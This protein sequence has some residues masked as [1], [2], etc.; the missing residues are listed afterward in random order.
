MEENERLR[1]KVGEML[2]PKISVIAA[3]EERQAIL[4]QQIEIYKAKLEVDERN[5][6]EIEK[7]IEDV[8]NKTADLQSRAQSKTTITDRTIEELEKLGY[9]CKTEGKH[10]EFIGP[11]GEKYANKN[12][13]CRAMSYVP[14]HKLKKK[15]ARLEIRV[16]S[17][18][19]K[20]NDS[21]SVNK[22][23]RA[24]IE[25][26]RKERLN[27]EQ[28]ASKL[29]NALISKK[30]EIAM[31]I[32]AM[33]VA[34]ETRD[35]ADRK[36]AHFKSEIMKNQIEFD[37]EWRALDDEMDS[38]EKRRKAV[39]ARIE[40]E[41]K[42]SKNTEEDAA[43]KAHMQ[44]LTIKFN[45]SKADIERFEEAYRKLREATALK[46]I[47][48][49]IHT[50]VEAEEHNFKL[51]SFLNALN[52]EEERLVAEVA[53]LGQELAELRREPDML[54]NQDLRRKLETQLAF[55]NSKAERYVELR[56][57]EEAR[58]EDML[59][60][61]RRMFHELGCT[62]YVD[63]SDSFAC[64]AGGP[65][66]SDSTMLTVLAMVERRAAELVLNLIRRTALDVDDQPAGQGIRLLNACPLGPGPTNP[67]GASTLK[68]V[69]PKIETCDPLPTAPRPPFHPATKHATPNATPSVLHPRPTRAP[70]HPAESFRVRRS[71]I[72]ALRPSD[73]PLA[74]AARPTHA[75]WCAFACVPNRSH[76]RRR[77]GTGPDCSATQRTLRG[78]CC[79][80]CGL[81]FVC[82]C[83][84]VRARACASM[85]V[86]AYLCVCVRRRACVCARAQGGQERGRVV[87]RGP[88]ERGLP[89]HDPGAARACACRVREF[90][91]ALRAH[92]G[93][94]V[95][96]RAFVQVR[97]CAFFFLCYPRA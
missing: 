44:E 9:K 15:L 47:D 64:D 7:T 51:F 27:F 45:A 12:E 46:D 90:V 65:I 32:E 86:C 53:R 30:A 54:S 52:R 37:N 63:A 70:R 13:V 77:K 28:I 96:A 97:A 92:T 25:H 6:E 18:L 60:I 48:E 40:E 82:M 42:R 19:M 67:M 69:A 91:R 55:V 16:H 34:L 56:Q 39:K 43:Q 1:M 74:S 4:N 85:S 38:E 3:F 14:D 49:L 22:E 80:C 8:T 75:A 11:Y 36:I 41:A 76:V 71:A 35:E 95:R 62:K 5:A 61:A 78:L 59:K 23:L 84:Y 88:R 33:N 79:V 93:A 50:F 66:V 72:H 58:V 2:R 57:E 24:E 89:P 20:F 87:G 10:T 29:Q 83:V 31:A 21:L 73:P 94:R 17:I 68:V 26:L 81:T